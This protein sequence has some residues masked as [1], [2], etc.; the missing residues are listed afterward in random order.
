MAK[1]KKTKKKLKLQRIRARMKRL[2]KIM[3]AIKIHKA[4][5]N[6]SKQIGNKNNLP[7]N[8]SNMLSGNIFNNRVKN[9]EGRISSSK[10]RARDLWTNEK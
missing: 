7:H 6:N 5:T 3:E 9:L 10:K 2:H 8:I 4:I 1:I